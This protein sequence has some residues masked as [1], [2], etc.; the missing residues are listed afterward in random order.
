MK[1]FKKKANHKDERRKVGKTYSTSRFNSSAVYIKQ[2]VRTG[3]ISEA[4][5]LQDRG[6]GVTN[7]ADPR[8]PALAAQE[9]G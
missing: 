9:R 6:R 4:G 3:I 1:E 8:M 7:C 5:R 2:K